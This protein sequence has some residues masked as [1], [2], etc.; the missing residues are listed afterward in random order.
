M[1]TKT[2]IAIGLIVALAV[3]VTAVFFASPDPD[4]LES[5]ALVTQGDKQLTGP[6][7]EDAEV[8]EDYP[9]RF[10]YESPLPDYTM[11]EEAGKPGEILALI[12]GIAIAFILVIGISRVVVR[13]ANKP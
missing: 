11:G 12:I 10:S 5:T 2:F 8:H 7:P 1:D 3:G 9:D 4:G 13:P 6:T